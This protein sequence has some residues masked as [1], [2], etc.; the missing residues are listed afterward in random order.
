MKEIPLTQGQIQIVDDE[1]CGWLNDMGSW[2][3]KWDSHTKS[4]RAARSVG[5]RLKQQTIRM[6]NVIWEHYN[7]PIPD[8]YTVDHINRDTLDNRLSNLRL[9]TKSQQMQNQGL[10]KDNTSGHRGVHRHGDKWHASISADGKRIHLGT[11]TDRADAD[12]AY[13]R[14]ALIHHPKFARLDFPDEVAS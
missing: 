12:S 14:A 13:N 2:F 8:G 11:F 4:F 5:P 3:A 9:A 7:D 10:R 1:D 6:H